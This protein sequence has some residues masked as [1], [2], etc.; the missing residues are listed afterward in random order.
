L[1]PQCIS[2]AT[3]AIEPPL[4][5]SPTYKQWK[6]PINGLRGF[7]IECGSSLT[8]QYLDRP[9]TT[10][11]FLGTVDEDVLCGA[12]TKE[13]HLGETGPRFL[14][15]DTGCGALLSRTDRS[16]HIWMENRIE[17]VTDIMP[18]VKWWRERSEGLGWEKEEELHPKSP[19]LIGK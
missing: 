4:D 8:F 1:I 14:R 10:E 3:S 11:I 7:C 5:S 2:I 16:G 18:G 13:E 17:G 19:V 15:D 9:Q 6:S 12:K